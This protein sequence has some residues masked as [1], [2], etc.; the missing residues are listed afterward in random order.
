MPS[1]P[2]G[3]IA[4]PGHE[5]SITLTWNASTG[6]DRY[7]I[8]AKKDTDK[9][10]IFVGETKGT[11][12]YL[13]NLSPDTRYYFRLYSVNEYGESKGYAYATAK[14]LK[15]SQDKL[16][17]KY[18]K[19]DPPY[20]I[21]KK[22]TTNTIVQVPKFYSRTY[23]VDLTRLE[24]KYTKAVQ[25]NIPIKNIRSSYGDI[26]ILVNGLK[27]N[28]PTDILKQNTSNVL[29]TKDA[30]VVIKAKFIDERE[31]SRLENKL[32]RN[33]SFTSDLYNLELQL[34]VERDVK[35]LQLTKNITVGVLDES[36]NSK[37][38]K[39]SKFDEAT[40]KFVLNNGTVKE[41]YD[42]SSKKNLNYLDMNTNKGGIFTLIR[43]N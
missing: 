19:E 3:F 9:D 1:T 35:D 17:D 23:T 2:Y 5:R 34:Q 8:Y 26:T 38:I 29:S 15:I 33:Q 28:L 32:N 21:L 18:T 36:T 31:K 13:N 25:I 12:Y 37:N 43:Q 4:K 22:S 41:I 16:D 14:T 11:E 7:K 39:I 20:A 30:N 27:V 24:D 40:N 6:S 10:Y 42:V